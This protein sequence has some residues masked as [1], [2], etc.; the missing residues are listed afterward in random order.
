MRKIFARLI[1]L[2]KNLGSKEEIE[3]YSIL[4]KEIKNGKV[5]GLR[6][7]INEEARKR[8]INFDWEDYGALLSWLFI[9][10]P[11]KENDYVIIDNKKCIESEIHKIVFKE[12]IMNELIIKRMNA[13]IEK[14]EKIQSI[15]DKFWK[16]KKALNNKKIEIDDETKEILKKG[17][18]KIDYREL[19]KLKDSMLMTK[20]AYDIAVSKGL[21]PEKSYLRHLY[22]Q[23]MMAQMGVIEVII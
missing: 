7:I 18:V 15:F 2:E 8:K 6:K 17:V 13:P 14:I 3:R 16:I 21:L 20:E 22:A 11:P 19:E 1:E 4:K 12:V 10:F 5:E 23:T 9:A